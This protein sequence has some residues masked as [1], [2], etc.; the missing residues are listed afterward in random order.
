MEKLIITVAPTGSFTTREDNPHLPITPDE[1][2]D[3]VIQSYEAGASLCHLHARDPETGVPSSNPKL[4]REYISR[5]REKCDVVVNFTTGGGRTTREHFD[6]K[7]VE[8]MRARLQSRPELASLNMGSINYW[9]RDVNA[10]GSS[11][12]VFMNPVHAVT[13]FAKLQLELGIK[14][15]LEIW[16]TGMIR[17]A[18][19]LMQRRI[20]KPP[21]HFQFVMGTMTGVQATPNNLLCL[22]QLIPSGSTWSVCAIGKHEFPMATMAILLGG[23]VRVGMEDNIY[24]EKRVLAKSNAELVAK[25]ARIAKELGRE[26]ATPTDAREIL[27]LR[28]T[29]A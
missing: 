17:V 29:K 10:I 21:L 9:F 2:V 11:T 15:E 25:V 6:P 12:G 3:E 24:I 4:F 7:D 16:D 27:G 18:I 14:P 28:S 8:I 22:T 13:A 20:L 23:H 5:I 19:D 26:L 1:I